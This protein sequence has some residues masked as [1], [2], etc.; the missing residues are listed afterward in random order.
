MRGRLQNSKSCIR[1]ELRVK[2]SGRALAIGMNM[3]TYILPDGRSVQVPYD[4]CRAASTID[5]MLADGRIVLAVI[6]KGER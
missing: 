6:A 3:I 5:F 2:I 4:V 1:N